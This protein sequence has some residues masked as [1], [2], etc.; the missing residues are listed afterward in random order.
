MVSNA[1]QIIDECTNGFGRIEPDNPERYRIANDNVGSLSFAR[2]HN[3][4]A[5]IRRPFQKLIREAEGSGT[6]NAVLKTGNWKLKAVH[7]SGQETAMRWQSDLCNPQSKL[8]QCGQVN[9]KLVIKSPQKEAC[10]AIGDRP[11]ASANYF[12]G[13]APRAV[14][15][16]VKCSHK[17][18]S[19]ARWD[20]GPQ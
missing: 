17:L 7:T 14:A 13:N 5:D 19:A 15:F 4:W 16:W 12:H 18:R 6:E 2:P 10:R 1:G 3:L 11:S 20:P 8:N 9:S